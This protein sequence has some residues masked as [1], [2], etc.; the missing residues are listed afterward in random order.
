LNYKAFRYIIRYERSLIYKRKT[1]YLKYKYFNIF[2]SRSDHNSV[3]FSVVIYNTRSKLALHPRHQR[4]EF[5]F[6]VI[7][8]YSIYW[9]RIILKTDDFLRVG[10]FYLRDVKN[11]IYSRGVNI[12]H[13]NIT[14]I[15]VYY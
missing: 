1:I 5:F 2:I 12:G 14:I 8:V 13:R 6:C 10:C 7:L 15:I 9:R 11:A 3:M 4:R